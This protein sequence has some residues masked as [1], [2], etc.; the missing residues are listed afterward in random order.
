MQRLSLKAFGKLEKSLVHTFFAK[1]PANFEEPPKAWKM[2]L[3][4]QRPLISGLDILLIAEAL[5]MKESLISN[6]NRIP[7]D[8][9]HSIMGLKLNPKKSKVYKEIKNR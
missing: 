9:F 7:P 3:R 5:N 1:N 8:T 6:P 4:N 2:C